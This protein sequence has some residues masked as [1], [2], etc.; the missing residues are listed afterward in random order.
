MLSYF[1]HTT[2]KQLC[3]Y[4]FLVDFFYV[5]AAYSHFDERQITISYFLLF[6]F[7]E[8]HF[9]RIRIHTKHHMEQKY[10]SNDQNIDTIN[11]NEKQIDREWR[12]Q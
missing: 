1:L 11:R 3:D 5:F 9:V 8:Q 12:K 6:L 10:D 2:Q 7:G 4:A